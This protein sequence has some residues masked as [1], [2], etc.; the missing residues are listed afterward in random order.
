MP[1]FF[2]LLLFSVSTRLDLITIKLVIIRK[3]SHFMIMCKLYCVYVMHEH[4]EYITVF[5]YACTMCRLPSVS[6]KTSSASPSVLQ[7]RTL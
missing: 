6:M 2:R 4:F 5:F 7:F 3:M 1:L